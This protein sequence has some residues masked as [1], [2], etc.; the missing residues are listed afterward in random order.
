MDVCERDLSMVMR[1]TTPLILSSYADYDYLSTFYIYYF[2][3]FYFTY[4]NHVNEPGQVTMIST[5][6]KTCFQIFREMFESVR[7]D[8]PMQRFRSRPTSLMSDSPLTLS[9]LHKI[10]YNSDGASPRAA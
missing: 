3:L 7:T 2:H 6:T 10:G 4:Y 8:K 1:K 9:D 5:M